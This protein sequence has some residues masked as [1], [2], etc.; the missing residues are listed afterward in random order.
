MIRPVLYDWQDYYCITRCKAHSISYLSGDEGCGIYPQRLKAHTM[1]K[2]Y[3]EQFGVP[4]RGG[5]LNGGINPLDAHDCLT[6]STRLFNY[7]CL[8][9]HTI[10]IPRLSTCFKSK[11]NMN[12]DKSGEDR[13]GIRQDTTHTSEGAKFHFRKSHNRLPFAGEC[14]DGAIQ[15]RQWMR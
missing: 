2:Y 15:L 3:T 8:K 5:F 14:S 13:L 6:S 9:M 1:L 7:V 12:N 4:P 10:H 11:L